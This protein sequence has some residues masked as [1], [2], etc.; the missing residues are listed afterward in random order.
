MKKTFKILALLL[1]ATLALT[2]LAACGL[3]PKSAQK[4]LEEKGYKVTST[5]IDADALK[6]FDLEEGDITASLFATKGEGAEEVH[7]S[8]IFCKNLDVARELYA[9]KNF[10]E[11]SKG[12]S[13]G[14]VNAI[15]WYGMEQGWDDA[16]K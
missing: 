8:I 11:V 9:N 4:A 15:I 10:Q 16:Q 7:V 3:S 2:A 1:V 6:L 14:R 12:S 5:D 13:R